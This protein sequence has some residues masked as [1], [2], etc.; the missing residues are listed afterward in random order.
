MCEQQKLGKVKNRFYSSLPYQG[1]L[2]CAVLCSCAK[3]FFFSSSIVG[4]WDE[5]RKLKACSWDEKMKFKP[6]CR[7]WDAVDGAEAALRLLQYLQSSVCLLALPNTD[8]PVTSRDALWNEKTLTVSF[9]NVNKILSPLLLYY[10]WRHTDQ[11]LQIPAAWCFPCLELSVQIVV[12]FQLLSVSSLTAVVQ[13]CQNQH[14]KTGGSAGARCNR[15]A[16]STQP[17]CSCFLPAHELTG[18]SMQ[19][20]NVLCYD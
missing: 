20:G 8:G 9:I 12:K 18:R 7:I 10:L 15:D 17:Q 16:Y 19:P 3:Y 6:D 1:V 14:L 11:V 5:K 2:L 4:V 13:C